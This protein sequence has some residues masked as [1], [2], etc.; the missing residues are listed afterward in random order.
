M[1]HVFCVFVM[2]YT[3][4]VRAMHIC[5][6][7]DIPVSA[8]DAYILFINIIAQSMLIKSVYMRKQV[9]KSIIMLLLWLL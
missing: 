8:C 6:D 3:T 9:S 4:V 5:M 2:L 1:M 7:Y